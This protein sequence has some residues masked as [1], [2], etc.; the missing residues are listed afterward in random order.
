MNE[1]VINEFL[2][3]KLEDGKTNIYVK[4]ERFDQCKYLMLNIPIDETHKFDEIESINEAADM[5]GWT[6]ERQEG[7]EHVENEID[8]ETEFWGHCSNLQAWYEHNYDTRLLHSNLAFPLLRKLVE[9]GDSLAKGVY[10]QEIIKRLGRGYPPVIEYIINERLLRFLD[11]KDLR[12]LLNQGFCG[13]S[14]SK[15]YYRNDQNEVFLHLLEIAENK[16]WMEELLPSFFGSMDKLCYYEQVKAYSELLKIAR[17]YG[18]LNDHYTAFFDYLN[19]FEG[20]Y[21]YH[22]FSDF[23]TSIRDSD[24]LNKYNISIKNQFLSLLDIDKIVSE[25]TYSAFLSLL[26]IARITKMTGQ[27]FLT[28]LKL[29]DS[30]NQFNEKQ[31]ANSSLV[32]AVKENMLRKDSSTLIRTNFLTLLKNIDIAS[33]EVE[34]AQYSTFADLVTISENMGFKKIFYNQ[35]EEIFPILFGKIFNLT[36]KQYE[37]FSNMLEVADKMGFVHKNYSIFLNSIGK[38]EYDLTAEGDVNLCVL[39]DLVKIAIKLEIVEEYL[40]QLESIT[41]SFIDD[42]KSSS[43]DEFSDI[44]TLINILGSLGLISKHFH[45]LIKLFNELKEEEKIRM[46]PILIDSTRNSVVR[47]SEEASLIRQFFPLFLK[48][49]NKFQAEFS[50]TSSITS[51]TY[52]DYQQYDHYLKL[53]SLADEIEVLQNNFLYFLNI[54][55]NFPSRYQYDTFSH[56]IYTAKTSKWIREFKKQIKFQFLKLLNNIE[57]LCNCGC[58]ESNLYDDFDEDDLDEEYVCHEYHDEEAIYALNKGIEG[59]FLEDEP[60]FKKIEKK[61]HERNDY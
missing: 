15:Q 50:I 40:D 22:A 34:F 14:S 48:L 13:S 7:V 25:H 37:A 39:S 6:E 24:L 20:I 30:L 27:Y 16:D 53:V 12:V 59:T 60:L 28:F 1:F 2:T 51:S 31:R 57:G 61:I 35:M 44:S 52:W 29:I 11:K 10:N 41:S 3:L 9:V 21:K 38:F 5:L 19:E 4:G 43:I 49:Y 8:P 55:V 36:W 56:L 58:Y 47:N 45:D 46:F 32:N 17:K 18:W 23:I 33:E 54:S 42:I 26:R